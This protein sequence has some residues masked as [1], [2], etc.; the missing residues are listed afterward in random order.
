MVFVHE[1]ESISAIEMAIK[2]TVDFGHF[3]GIIALGDGF[4]PVENFVTATFEIAA[5]VG[6][7]FG[8]FGAAGN[9]D[10][11]HDGPL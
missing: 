7:L 3:D 2:T 10:F 9:D 8:K 11:F 1:K 5:P 6:T 4:G